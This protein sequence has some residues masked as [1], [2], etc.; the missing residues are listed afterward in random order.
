LA[1]SFDVKHAVKVV[2]SA[3]EYTVDHA[4]MID[5]PESNCGSLKTEPGSQPLVERVKV[6]TSYLPNH[7]EHQ[8][9]FNRGDLSLDPTGHV[10]P[11]SA[12]T[13]EREVR[14]GELRRNRDQKQ[15]RLG[16]ADDDRGPHLSRC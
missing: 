3:A 4:K 16:F 8:F 15:V 2:L 12:P 10:Q 14:V 11:G 1:I 9:S 5:I 7:L 6:R 13:G